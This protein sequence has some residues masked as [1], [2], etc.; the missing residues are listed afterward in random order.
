M[1]G[2][3]RIFLHYRLDLTT[4]LAL[5]RRRCLF[6]LAHLLDLLEGRCKSLRRRLPT[7][8]VFAKPS[9]DG[10]V[11]ASSLE[12]VLTKI[13]LHF[14][15]STPMRQACLSQV[16]FTVPRARQEEFSVRVKGVTLVDVSGASSARPSFTSVGK[17]ARLKALN[18]GSFR[19]SYRLNTIFRVELGLADPADLDCGVLIPSSCYILCVFLVRYCVLCLS[20][21]ECE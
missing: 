3:R 14:N 1:R 11:D 6:K 18:L 15:S 5:P 16:A 12:T 7:V 9:F 20:L 21:S 8:V 2:V 13:F 4:S 19:P 10:L 17:D